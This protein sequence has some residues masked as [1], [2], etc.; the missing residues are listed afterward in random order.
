MIKFFRKIRQNL[1]MENKTGKYFKYAIGEI[2]LVV[3]GI[4]IAL[5][6]NNW[7][8]N[9]LTRNQEV[10]YLQ[11]LKSELINNV[12][13]IEK[14]DKRYEELQKNNSKGF[15][16]FNT[17][18][19][20]KEFKEIDSLIGTYWSTFDVNRSTY[21]E[22][23]STG[24]FYS[25]KNKTIRDLINIHYVKAESDKNAFSEMNSNNQEIYNNP[26]LFPLVILKD[27]LSKSPIN[28]KDIDT[29]W[30]HNPNSKIYIT[31]FKKVKFT[32][33][34]HRH[35]RSIISNF[36]KQSETLIDALSEELKEFTND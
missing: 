3:I 29:S 36:I 8:Q 6:I 31:Y 21:D 5:G 14:L 7:N 12:T 35:R 34:L 9:R 28:L 13:V 24:S 18:S 10:L 26:N 19:S 27:R 1:L 4:L 11:N 16:Q 32:E 22:M 20:I 17:I 30:I 15:N 2:I 33:K 23:L 25:L